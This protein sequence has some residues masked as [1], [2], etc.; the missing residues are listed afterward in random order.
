MPVFAQQAPPPDLTKV[1]LED[2]MNLEVTSAARK[3]QPVIDVTSA[4]FVITRDDI[5]RSGLTSVPEILRLAP[6]VQVA[7]ID[8]S[9]WAVSIRGFNNRWSDELLVLLDGRSLYS[10]QFSGIDWDSVGV[11]IDDIERIEVIRGSGGAIWCA[12]AVDGVID[13]ITQSSA[14]TQGGFVKASAGTGS[15]ASVTARYGAQTGQTSWRLSMDGTEHPHSVLGPTAP[16]SD[17]WSTFTAN[18]R[19]DRTVGPNRLTVLADAMFGATNFYFPMPSGVT[20]P[21]DGWQPVFVPT[22][23]VSTSGL[24]RWTHDLAANRS[25]ELQGSID[26]SHRDD[27]IQVLDEGAID[28]D[29]TYH[30]RFGRHDLVAGT[31]YRTAEEGSAG[32][33]VFQMTPGRIRLNTSD[34]F[35]Q[36]E[37][38]LPGDRVRLTGGAKV[39]HDTL[40]GWGVQPSGRVLVIL[41]PTQRLWAAASR[42]LRD[43]AVVDRGMR[44][45][46]TTF[47]TATGLP[48]IVSLFGDPKYSTE[49]TTSIE[50]GYRVETEHASI[51][52][53]TFFSHHVGLTTLEPLAPMVETA[54]G[55]PDLLIGS[56]LSNLTGA[57]TRGLEASGRWMPVGGLRIDGSLTAFG[58]TPL[59]GPLSLDLAA[60]ADDGSAPVLQATLHPSLTRGRLEGDLF[61]SHVG[62]LRVL[63]VPAYTRVDLNLGWRADARWSVGV[64][65][66]NI[67]SAGHLEFAGQENFAT[68]MEQPR[69]AAVQIRWHF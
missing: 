56:Q 22:N 60:S 9:K 3:E 24:V 58:F 4:V 18:S 11:V 17:A 68:S 64:T 2:L 32:T 41:T 12:N 47:P 1:S 37:I 19:I 15:A 50:G 65:L 62:A 25:I 57:N 40:M 34:F 35:A 27:G 48:A 44:L 26:H 5:R 67:T 63:G 16:D 33:F 52:L 23:V 7:Q 54:Y 59:P 36:D 69:R 51:D 42:A 53:S 46:F 29:A 21:A 38:R 14:D 20:A 28:L 61:L 49:A 55:S 39:G 6:G 43:P 8:A 66:Q 13:I 10:R 45:N 30:G 31:E